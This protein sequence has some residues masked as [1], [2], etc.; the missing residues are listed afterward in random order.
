MV[1]EDSP[2]YYVEK[3]YKLPAKSWFNVGGWKSYVDKTPAPTRL[4]GTEDSVRYLASYLRKNGPFDG[5]L[6]FS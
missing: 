2:K 1:E 6:A 3:G 4:Y 5:V